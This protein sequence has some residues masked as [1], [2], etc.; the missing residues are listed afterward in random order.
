MQ[1]TKRDRAQVVYD[2]LKAVQYGLNRKTRIKQK[3]NLSSKYAEM[4]LEQLLK[5]GLLNKLTG[6][7][8]DR[9]FITTKGK[10]YIQ[11]YNRIRRLL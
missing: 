8:H 2:T 3:A 6:K 11:A 9:Y 4:I 5:L 7:Y 1:T 10:E